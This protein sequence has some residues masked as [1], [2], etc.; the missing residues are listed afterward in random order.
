MGG[1]SRDP[2]ER[3][4]RA[5]ADDERRPTRALESAEPAESSPTSEGEAQLRSSGFYASARSETASLRIML[6]EADEDRARATRRDLRRASADVIFVKSAPSIEDARVLLCTERFDVL[7]IHIEGP[8]GSIDLE[9]LDR[10]L[11]L[12]GTHDGEL[13]VIATG[14]SSDVDVAALACSKGAED[15]LSI[16]SI[17]STELLHA[18]RCACARARRTVRL[19]SD[20]YHDELTHLPNRRML[21]RQFAE[22]RFRATRS[23]GQVALLMI[24]L[25]GFKSVNDTLGHGAGDELLVAVAGRLRACVRET[26]L[27]ARVGGD[28]FVV[29]TNSI[30]GRLCIVDLRERIGAALREPFVVASR[31]IRVRASIG[32]ATA[33]PDE[34]CDLATMLRAADTEMY[35]QKRIRHR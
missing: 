23:Q 31:R 16:E 18:L 2:P 11:I 19:T 26:D 7:V 20:A 29:L 12:A 24:D 27:V 22:A 6:V 21:R 4:I 33:T 10:A 5:I 15:F 3:G 17:S 9:A 32:A 35:H 13:A 1:A 14:S 8:D 28:E 25:D 30:L 34:G